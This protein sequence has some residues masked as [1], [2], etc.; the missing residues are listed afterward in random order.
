METK[1]TVRICI[2]WIVL[3]FL[4][5]VSAGFAAVN[6]R[7]MQGLGDTRYKQMDSE[8]VGRRY[9][10]FIMLPDGYKQSSE[11]KYPTIYLLDGG[12]LFPLLSAYYC[13][14]FPRSLARYRFSQFVADA[15]SVPSPIPATQSA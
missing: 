2:V 15:L 13:N 3:V 4:M 14:K 10:I 5:T 6:T 7:F 1:E 12:A 9:H 8:I 11:E